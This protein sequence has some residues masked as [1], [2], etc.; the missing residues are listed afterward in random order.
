MS[1]CPPETQRVALELR[2]EG[3]PDT[4]VRLARAG[5]PAPRGNLL[6][7]VRL[8]GRCVIGHFNHATPRQGAQW[9]TEAGPSELCVPG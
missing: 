5:D 9:I 3:Y 4:T 6:Y 1:R 8:G 2:M 7:A